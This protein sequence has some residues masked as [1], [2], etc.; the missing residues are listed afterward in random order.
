VALAELETVELPGC[1]TVSDC[2][3]ASDSSWGKLPSTDWP[4]SF[5]GFGYFQAVAASL[6][7]SGGQLP[8][9]LRLVMRLGAVVSLV[10]VVVM[11]VGG[12]LCGYCVTIHAAIL[13]LVG[14]HVYWRC[15]PQTV[16]ASSVATPVGSF[17]AT[18]VLT[19]LLL[20][21]LDQQTKQAAQQ[22]T[23]SQLQA[24]LDH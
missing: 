8:R 24:A 23:R 10:L 6:L 1:A 5:V 7:V 19:S 15:R 11:L 22:A 14:T 13:L 21:W 2:S 18:F 4:L 20:G 9:L 16:P 17:A 12:Y 3:R